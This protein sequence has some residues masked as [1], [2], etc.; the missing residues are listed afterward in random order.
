MGYKVRTLESSCLCQSILQQ[1]TIMVIYY[2]ESHDW[3]TM[4]GGGAFFV[5]D[6]NTTIVEADK[7]LRE[8]LLQAIMSSRSFR[9]S[10]LDQV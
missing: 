8:S 7:V 5:T 2:K 9:L 4:L 1:L 6:Q 10:S 3:G